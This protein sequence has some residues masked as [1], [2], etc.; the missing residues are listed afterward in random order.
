MTVVEA[1]QAGVPTVSF[2]SSPGTRALITPDTGWLVPYDNDTSY[3]SALRGALAH[4][5]ELKRRGEAAR[6]HVSQF[7][8]STVVNRW[9]EMVEACYSRRDGYPTL[10]PCAR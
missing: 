2:D 7:D 8:V 1:A 4:P 9:G 5:D 3:V 10:H 6:Q